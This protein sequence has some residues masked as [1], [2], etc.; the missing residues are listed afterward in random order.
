MQVLYRLLR[1]CHPSLQGVVGRAA[2]RIGRGLAR[3]HWPDDALRDYTTALEVL[4]VSPKERNISALVPYRMVALADLNGR[5]AIHPTAIRHAYD[6][7]SIVAHQG[8]EG[9]A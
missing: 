3:H 4:L 7:R 1:S 8:Y 2:G 6:R 9:A 5:A